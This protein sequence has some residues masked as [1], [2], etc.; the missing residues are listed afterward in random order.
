MTMAPAIDWRGLIGF[1]GDRCKT[2][3]V[4]RNRRAGRFRAHDMT[5]DA[6]LLGDLLAG[7]RIGMHLRGGGAGGQAQAAKA[8]VMAISDGFAR[9]DAGMWGSRADWRE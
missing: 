7:L 6:E 5:A 3:H 2:R 9:G 4:D 1:G 8:A